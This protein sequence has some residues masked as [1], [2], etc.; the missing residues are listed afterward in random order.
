[1]FI[2]TQLT[3]PIIMKT[4]DTLTHESRYF[5]EDSIKDSLTIGFFY[6]QN[7]VFQSLPLCIVPC[8]KEQLRNRTILMNIQYL[9]FFYFVLSLIFIKVKPQASLKFIRTMKE[10]LCF[11]YQLDV[12]LIF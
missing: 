4:N 3:Q 1:M 10:L 12:E 2:A 7:Y 9:M 5:S 11:P 8:I 6:T